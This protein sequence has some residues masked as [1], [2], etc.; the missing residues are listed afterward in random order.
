MKSARVLCFFVL[1]TL[2][3]AVF[4]CTAPPPD[5]G[6][7]ER[8]ENQPAVTTQRS[9]PG[10]KVAKPDPDPS[11][12]KAGHSTDAETEE[13][14]PALP[15]H[16]LKLRLASQ[17]GIDLTA[18]TFDRRDF[19]LKVLDQ[20]GGPGSRFDDAE[21]AARSIEGIAAING[22]FFS[23]EGKPVGLVISGGE[24]RGYFN[25]SSFLGT[26]IL[27]GQKLR[28]DTRQSYRESSELLQSGPRLVWKDETL[29]GLSSTN[30]RPRS[31][32]IWD[33]KEHFG[34]AH[35]DSASL[36]GL[37]QALESQPLSGFTIRYAV[38]FDGGTSCDLWVGPSVPGGD[39]TK[40]SFFRKKARNYLVLKER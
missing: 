16:P 15:R 6:S 13:N 38:N 10:P 26:G 28:L 29:T 2:A 33:G 24:K 18:V 19:Q 3:L 31:F 14:G 37:S 21:A 39:L 30:P 32:L 11:D 34:L 8:P 7:E 23:P 9:R 22:G 36:K 17:N 35:A 20:K 4:S 5:P 25:S 1:S 12:R 27:D 40:C